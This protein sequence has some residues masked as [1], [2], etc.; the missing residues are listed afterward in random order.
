MALFSVFQLNSRMLLF[1]H[2]LVPDCLY[3]FINIKKITIAKMILKYF[4]YQ[5]CV[6]RPH[7]LRE[8]INTRAGHCTEDGSES[9]RSALGQ[10]NSIA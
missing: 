8:K 2:R 5:V 9:Q 4:S 6:V 7:N 10:D 3:M 1:L